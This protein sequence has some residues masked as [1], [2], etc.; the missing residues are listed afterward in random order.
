MTQQDR[1]APEMTLQLVQ[2]GKQ[3]RQRGPASEIDDFAGTFSGS[4]NQTVAGDTAGSGVA[5]LTTSGNPQRKN[6]AYTFCVDSITRVPG[7]T[8]APVTSHCQDY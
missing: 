6:I 2:L 5:T 7:L 3:P 1:T 4:F 8:Y